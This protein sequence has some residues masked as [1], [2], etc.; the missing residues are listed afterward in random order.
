MNLTFRA[1]EV[2]DSEI[3]MTFLTPE[4]DGSASVV[5]VLTDA[6]LSSVSTQ[7]QLLTLVT[8]KLQRKVHKAGIA[9]KLDQFVGQ[10]ITI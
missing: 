5:I 6:E 2:R 4:G 3:G 1:Y 8:T 7:G 10:M 9:S